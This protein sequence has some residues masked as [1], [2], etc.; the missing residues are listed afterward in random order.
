MHLP[1]KYATKKLISIL[2][3]LLIFPQKTDAYCLANKIVR[4]FL[5]VCIL[6]VT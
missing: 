3:Y 1:Q 4:I 2:H 5:I 6:L